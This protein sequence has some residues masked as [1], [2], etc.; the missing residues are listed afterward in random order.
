[1]RGVVKVL[2]IVVVGLILWSCKPQALQEAWV[3]RGD[4]MYIR[5][6]ML[7]ESDDL[8]MGGRIVPRDYR[9]RLIK[10]GTEGQTL[11]KTD[12]PMEC[13]VVAS[14][15]EGNLYT[16]G[17]YKDQV[18]GHYHM[19]LG[20][21]TGN[22]ECVW[23]NLDPGIDLDPDQIVLD[24]DQDMLIADWWDGTLGTLVKFDRNG[25]L[26]WHQTFPPYSY[27][28]S[29]KMSVDDYGDVYL[30]DNNNLFDI[31][32]R[33]YSGIT[34]ALL[35]E[36]TYD[37]PCTSEGWFNVAD[38]M[39]DMTID[40]QGNVIVLGNSA[41]DAH[42]ENMVILKYSPDGQLLWKHERDPE[43]FLEWRNAGV[44][45]VA[46]DSDDNIIATWCPMVVIAVLPYPMNP[47]YNEVGYSYTEVIKLDKDGTLL[48]SRK[49]E[50]SESIMYVL[51][52]IGYL[53]ID[54]KDDIH[55]YGNSKIYHYDPD[56]NLIWGYQT[57]GGK[58]NSNFL[59]VDM[60]GMPCWINSSYE[61]GDGYQIIKYNKKH[62]F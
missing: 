51:P 16:A 23:T 15:T 30:A 35:W 59:L 4:D 14:D 27:G 52:E 10:I 55:Y 53:T 9:G 21:Y 3:V 46:V 42:Y 41:K 47:G 33:K 40:N 43:G 57:T 49:G 38:M 25:G 22:G 44:R 39:A 61:E 13:T 34:G 60:A 37:G 36:R 11:W 6:A 26:L 54:I 17:R 5:Q 28:F 32:L 45:Q 12:A 18:D 48:W 19:G 20:K 1:M 62:L 58:G 50:I 8:I 56:G 7:N 2:G 31:S 29:Q 24:R